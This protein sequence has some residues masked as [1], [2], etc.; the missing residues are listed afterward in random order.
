MN[1]ICRQA[2]QRRRGATYLVVAATG[3]AVGIVIVTYRARKAASSKASP[4]V[5]VLPNGVHQEL[6]GF[7][8]TRSEG[9]RRIFTIRASRTLSL[10][11][12]RRA[13]LQDVYVEFFGR[14][15]AQRDILR[16]RQGEYD[17][18]SGNFSS[19]ANVEIEL[20]APP[21]APLGKEL[22]PASVSAHTPA[23]FSGRQ[24]VILETSHVLYQQRQSLLETR[25]PVRFTAGPV[26]GTA[27]GMTY[28]TRA[29]WLQLEQQVEI[30]FHPA[31]GLQLPK[32]IHLSASRFRYDH[33]TGEGKFWGPVGIT[34]AG[35]TAVAGRAQVLL[36]SGN[37][38][39][40]AILAGGFE[41]SG[42]LPNGEIHLRGDRLEGWLV[43]AT[44]QLHALEALGHV[45]GTTLNAQAS[46][47]IDADE[48]LVDFSKG[49][50]ASGE[51]LG[52]VE[53]HFASPAAR[54]EPPAASSE[55]SE[56]LTTARLRFKL[57]P[58]GKAVQEAATVGPGV[59]TILPQQSTT[60]RQKVSAGQLRFRFDPHD[61]LE[62]LVGLR[63]TRLASFPAANSPKHSLPW[64]STA[65][66][67]T[68][69]FNPAVESLRSADQDGDF[70]YE[71]GAQQAA[72]D[73]AHYAAVDQTLTLTG[74]PR[75]WNSTTHLQA[76]QIKLEQRSDAVEGLGD[77]RAT[78]V[79]PGQKPALPSNVLA[80]RVVATHADEEVRFQGHVRAWHGMD[81]IEAPALELFG[82]ERRVSAGPSV[83]SSYLPSG[84][85]GELKPGAGAVAEAQ[86][87]TIQADHLDYFDQNRKASYTGHV[88]M[89]T[90]DSVLRADRLDIYFS[91]AKSGKGSEIVRAMVE[92]HVEVTQPGRRATG[93][94]AVYDARMGEIVMTG[95]PPTLYD[96]ARGLTTGRRLTFFTRNDSVLVD[97]GRNFIRPP[98]PRVAP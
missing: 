98:R 3:L 69:H 96:V 32:P 57:R 71:R 43:P 18:V 59:L 7:A 41:L 53:A 20:N 28:G 39:T 97:E 81:V 61:R 65:Q 6:S 8:F 25:S 83:V 85:P 42:S 37:R 70:R 95:G 36:D 11:K 64:E 51:A 1:F 33:D 68:A 27:V 14:S 60:A 23:P 38:I 21:E 91:P 19:T 66:R 56:T 31:T 72:A 94:R 29:G 44:E 22:P 78:Y 75:A 74:H 2:E 12:G 79:E 52:G 49:R 93:D 73:H 34:E 30:T 86:P 55:A 46:S 17:A 26:S 47:R 9:G 89:K 77:V 40:Q 35:S 87:V 63:G 67:L 16:T 88:V 90:K 5:S 13:V 58:G 50:P 15:G 76:N 80:D 48:V 84:T 24:P 10:K 82:R 54:H 92:G 62:A 4:P 45:H